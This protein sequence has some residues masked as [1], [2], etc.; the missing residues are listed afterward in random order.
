MKKLDDEEYLK[1]DPKLQARLGLNQPVEDAQGI[2][3]KNIRNN[4]EGLGSNSSF[5]ESVGHG[6]QQSPL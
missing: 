2:F 4:Y 3:L 1:N 6:Q 5:Q